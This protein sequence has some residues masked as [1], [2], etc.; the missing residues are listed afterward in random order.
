M[1]QISL[2]PQPQFSTSIKAVVTTGFFVFLLLSTP[3]IIYAGEYVLMK[4]RGVEVCEIYKKNLNSFGHIMACERKINPKF[5]D[6]KKPIWKKLDLW[7]NRELLRR[8]EKF[9]EFG[10]QHVE[11][12]TMYDNTAEFEAYVKKSIPYNLNALYTTKIDIN[13]DK[14]VE[15]ILR[16][17]RGR[18]LRTRHFG[19][20]I[21]V[22]D[23]TGQSID[24]KR[25]KPLLQNRFR[26][27]NQA[28]R[29]SYNL[30]DIFRYKKKMYFD[31]WDYDARVILYVFQLKNNRSK[32]ICKYK[33]KQ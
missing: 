18:C 27:E 12:G 20:P 3:A 26:T 4:G 22:L 16:Y 11:S 15:I 6:L 31:K 33:Y 23:N 17:K 24:E 19:I 9:L 8:A 14:K 21:L 28:G 10:S 2:I 30:Y 13:N 5:A 29:W 1:L 32:M 7:E 25:S